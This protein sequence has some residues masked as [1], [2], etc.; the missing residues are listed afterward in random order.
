MARVELAF[1]RAGSLG[2]TTFVGFVF[3]QNRRSIALCR[4]F[5]FGQWGHLP[6]VAVLDGVERDLLIFGRRIDG[7]PNPADLQ[8]AG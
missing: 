4:K 7:V 6:R 8:P 3:A 1:A 2:L 5:G